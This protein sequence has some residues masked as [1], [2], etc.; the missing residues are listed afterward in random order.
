[1]K[2]LTETQRGTLDFI[3][4]YVRD[5]GY[6]PTI[7]EIGAACGGVR[8]QAVVDRL[9]ALERKGYISRVIGSPRTICVLEVAA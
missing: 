6:P 4:A 5:H 1:M 9:I 7:R 2:A 3:V 8:T